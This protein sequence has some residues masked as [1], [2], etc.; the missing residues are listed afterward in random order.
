MRLRMFIVIVLLAVVLGGVFGW[1][2]FTNHM[3]DQ[4]IA[5]MDA[6]PVTVATAPAEASEWTN[7][8]RVTG[9]VVAIQGVSVSG[10]VAGIVRDIQFE[11]GD[12]VEAGDTLVALD[13]AEDRARL[14]GLPAG[15]PSGG[16]GRVSEPRHRPGDA[17]AAG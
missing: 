10:E 12:R 7:T 8:L 15:H 5:N 17:T 4:F 9:E 2:L 16:S 14:E 1:K 3:R 13:T 11:S 6:P